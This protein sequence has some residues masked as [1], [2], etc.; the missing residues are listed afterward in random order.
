MTRNKSLTRNK[1]RLTPCLS[2]LS[3]LF[4]LPNMLLLFLKR[5]MA[6]RVGGK[7]T[8]VEMTPTPMLSASNCSTLME[9]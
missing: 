3:I 6:S 7:T 1:I 9:K 4:S 2:P 8:R 5:R